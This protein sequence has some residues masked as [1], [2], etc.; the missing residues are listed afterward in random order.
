M[1]ITKSHLIEIIKEEIE[2][3]Q[4]NEALD[5]N[6]LKNLPGISSN[7]QDIRNDIAEAAHFYRKLSAPG[8]LKMMPD[9][10]IEAIM[11]H[12]SDEKQKLN[13]RYQIARQ[14]KNNK[15]SDVNNLKNLELLVLHLDGLFQ[16]VRDNKMYVAEEFVLDPS[17]ED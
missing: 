14:L 11:A 12:L 13:K 2:N 16:S 8:V 3:A 9:E 6:L 4:L 1:K 10:N 7:D 5:R 15:F 17:R